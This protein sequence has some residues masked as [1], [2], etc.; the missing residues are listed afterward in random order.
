MSVGK[1]SPCFPQRD[2]LRV[3][4]GFYGHFT[5]GTQ[6]L[7][8]KVAVPC[9][10]NILGLMFAACYSFYMFQY[11]PVVSVVTVV[12]VVTSLRCFF[13]ALFACTPPMKY[14]SCM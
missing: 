6:L 12:P 14:S 7:L 4:I 11:I 13:F 3:G 5:Q 8:E 2:L 9:C 10:K 1:G